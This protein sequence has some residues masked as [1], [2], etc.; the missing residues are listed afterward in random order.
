M[1]T[2]DTIQQQPPSKLRGIYD[3]LNK[4]GKIR[5]GRTYEDWEGRMQDP[6]KLE[7]VYNY[8]K[9]QNKVRAENFDAFSEN[10]GVKKK[11]EG[12]P[13]GVPLAPQTDPSV[14]GSVDSSQPLSPKFKV[15]GQSGADNMHPWAVTV[16]NILA[17]TLG[18]DLTF[19]SV[20]R[21]KK[22]NKEVG[23]VDD[24]FHL[25]GAGLDV[26]PKDWAKVS[27][28]VRKKLLDLHAQIVDEGDHIHIE[29]DSKDVLDNFKP[30]ATKLDSGLTEAQERERNLAELNRLYDPMARSAMA[31]E[32]NIQAPTGTDINRVASAS[33]T[34]NEMV[35]DAVASVPKGYGIISNQAERLFNAAV[36]LPEPKIEDNAGYNVGKWI[37][38]KAFDVG[39]TA[40]NP[41][42]Q[43]SFF[44]HDVP[45]ALGSVFSIIA[46][47][48]RSL[49]GG[50]AAQ[51]LGGVSRS[52]PVAEAAKQLGKTLS[53][54]PMVTSGLMMGV[55][56]Y[57]QAIASGADEDTAFNAFLSNYE[58]GMTEAIPV[59]RALARI[60]KLSGG[61]IIDVLKT[62]TV[63]SIEEASQEGV[64]QILTNWVAQGTY[65]PER[66]PFKDM[67]RSM[68]AGAF[69]AFILPG[70]GMAMQKMSPD[71]RRRTQEILNEEFKA[72]KNEADT[73]HAATPE[74]TV[75]AP[76]GDLGNT[77]N[78]PSNVPPR[79]TNETL[80]GS[81]DNNTGQQNDNTQ[82]QP[83][84]TVG[85]GQDIS[86]IK[87]SIQASPV[88]GQQSADA[89]AN[90][91]AADVKILSN[92]LAYAVEQNKSYGYIQGD[93]SVK[94]QP[95]T[96]EN[97]DLERDRIKSLASKGQL[98]PE[99]MSASL[100]GKVLT[101]NE[102]AGISE[103]L[104]KNPN[105]VDEVFEKVKARLSPNTETSAD[106]HP[107][108]ISEIT[109]AD[110]LAGMYMDEV[111]NPSVAHE[112]VAIAAVL[113][114]TKVARESFINNN[115]ATN[116]T[117]GMAKSYFEKGGAP[118]DVIAKQAGEKI[119]MEVTPEQ[120]A[121]FMI[122]YKSGP[123]TLTTPAGN[124]KLAEIANQYATVTGKAINRR[125]AA[126]AMDRARKAAN[127][128]VFSDSFL[129]VALLADTPGSINWTDPQ[130][131]EK[132]TSLYGLSEDEYVFLSNF[133]GQTEQ[134]T[135]DQGSDEHRESAVPDAQ[136]QE[137]SVRE[138]TE[139]PQRPGSTPE[140]PGQV[141]QE[142]KG[143]TLTHVHGLNMGSGVAKGTYLSTEEKNRYHSQNSQVSAA[144]V[145][146]TSPRL[147]TDEDDI[148]DLRNNI[149][150]SNLDK[151][152]IT[153]FVAL[154]RPD[155]F[156]VTID[157][158]SDSGIDKLAGMVSED[159]IASGH[160]SVYFRESES[161]EGEL[162][163]FDRAKVKFTTT[164][165]DSETATP[166]I[167]P[168]QTSDPE[169][170]PV[171]GEIQPI[172]ENIE[173]VTNADHPFPIG[174]EVEFEWLGRMLIGKVKEIKENSRV[175][176]ELPDGRTYIKAPSEIERVGVTAKKA[177]PKDADKTVAH[178]SK[179]KKPMGI[180]G[181]PANGFMFQTDLKQITDFFKK[182][183][184]SKGFLPRFVFDRWVGAKG[185]ISAFEAKIKFTVSDFKAAVK[186]EYGG[187]KLTDDQI[188][189]LNLYLQGKAPTNPVPPETTKML[190]VMRAQ[191]DHLSNRFIN[192][193]IISGNLKATFTQNLGVY[194]TRSYRKHDDPFWAEFVPDQVRNKAEAFIRN[195][196][197]SHGQT[198]TNEEVEGLINFILHDPKAP[199]AVLAGSKLGSK[200]LSILKKRGDIAPEI[201]ALMGEYGDPL[202]NYQRTVTKMVNLIAK[203][204]FLEDVRLNGIGKFLFEKP[205][206][207]YSVKLAA[208]GSKTM[209][210]LNGLH[211]SQEIADAF[212]E[213]NSQEPLPTWLRI[214]MKA[215]SFVKA[216][217]TVFSIQTHARNIMGNFGFVV[218]NGHWRA[219]KAGQASQIAWAQLYDSDQK[220]RDKYQ[221]YIAL[222]IV[223]DSAAG[224]ELRQYI[225]DVRDGKDFFER[226]GEKSLGKASRK[227]LDVT[228]QAYQ[229]E[230]DMFKIYA[231]ENEKARYAKAYPNL[232]A[233]EL[234]EKVAKI[235]RDT[236]PTYSMVPKA[237]QGLRGNPLIGTFV[238]FPA[239]V[240]RTTYN[241]MDLAQQEIRNPET[242][243][244]GAQRMAGI[245]LA[246]GLPTA[247]SMYTMYANGMDGDDDDD[248]R[249]FAAPWQTDSEFLYLRTDKDKYTV[250][251]LGYSDPHNYLKRPFYSFMNGDNLL[252]G[253]IDAAQA[254]A[255]PFLDEN[256][257]T[258]R[259]IDIKRNKKANGDHVYNPDAP[260]G[261]QLSAS[262]GHLWP[263]TEPGT[264]AS[265]RRIRKGALGETDKYGKKYELGSELLGM[266]SGQKEE[267]KDITQS[268]LY[269]AYELKDRIEATE[270]DYFRVTK[271]LEATDEQ[272][273]DAERVRKA[274]MEHIVADAKD[275]YL[276]AIRLGVDPKQ[277]RRSMILTKSVDIFR[278]IK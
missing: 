144:E 4:E 10:V 58:I 195:N 197:A 174:T 111:N 106:N 254:L 145:D 150:R 11:E 28:S 278:A 157:F 238:S 190:D 70:I 62:G 271:N 223:Q 129:E 240:F 248:I 242:R 136:G 27:D 78:N 234:G 24:S 255:R 222:G 105:L 200:D 225:K 67:L 108:E 88:Q 227:L 205:T 241:S 83:V 247:A 208:D 149:L 14:L 201:R 133:Y 56:E 204:H 232:P 168:E 229:A 162:I 61:K 252:D 155:I 100:W 112:D 163:V 179:L 66:A 77:S 221:E 261:D 230:D 134:Q 84:S 81:A 25:A 153:D 57:E 98:T 128:K 127:N 164:K 97:I 185:E 253:G 116:I 235:I 266:V 64:Q 6:V 192:E 246:L 139:V 65:D 15:S 35:V 86:G 118:L 219:N 273:K 37:Q 258:E 213:F 211:T 180:V 2:P 12:L 216:N 79:S 236:Y 220:I 33:G 85:P 42:L 5:P 146:I 63:G 277:A 154:E 224:G 89:Q 68:G 259:L 124:P 49:V 203:H 45:A 125:T 40:T 31:A 274:A 214:Y 103:T 54:R 71:Q 29:P 178:N 52:G 135:A 215:I 1:E 183:F 20:F 104:N 74:P 218:M 173:P 250:V 41:D 119:G 19:N 32:K 237:I 156:D 181:D 147:I 102:V 207:K 212:N 131:R 130:I 160:D 170:Q 3:Y 72:M 26:N 226:L 30:E 23:G 9:G 94:E 90:V 187:K 140:G 115:D 132:L 217:K 55:S 171:A 209:A 176:I 141:V 7:Q 110:E 148:I 73:K 117:P 50:K 268:L 59:E 107:P 114:K 175:V 256:M 243:D 159:L 191:I 91:A 262:Y 18:D 99:N 120:V 199:M 143:K 186:T 82:G 167:Q 251:D 138:G 53:S 39:I 177:A 47:Q 263:V 188:T 269:R 239:E 276:S 275:I 13:G 233:Q 137:T 80:P 231:F 184:T 44:F 196:A 69:V 194:L 151:F 95:S 96:L 48:G 51:L 17:D 165:D 260:V 158:L 169:V 38:D 244:I 46:S 113:S 8:L 210:P 101:T 267:T 206:G 36:G 228:Q 75:N 249:K 60:N 202:L 166:V 257:L 142:I 92:A 264:I 245:I 123:S 121:E 43:D 21:T 272:K 161:Q 76:T 152:D 198:I 193:G 109:D 122:R 265:L 34:F 22:H 87:R 270:K 93:G 16:G 126:Q 182:Q 172:E 189:D